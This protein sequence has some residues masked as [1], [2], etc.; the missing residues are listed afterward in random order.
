[1]SLKSV[2]NTVW[3]VVEPKG[4][5]S[6]KE[7]LLFGKFAKHDGR[8]AH[9]NMHK[10][11]AERESVGADDIKF[12]G[13]IKNEEWRGSSLYNNEEFRTDMSVFNE[14]N[15]SDGV[16]ED[17]SDDQ[18]SVWIR[19]DALEGEANKNRDCTKAQL[20]EAKKL[21]KEGKFNLVNP[22]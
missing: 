7:P 12:A 18:M 13:S 15:M 16:G 1:M 22:R 19:E 2:N 3:F 5:G 11:L 9:M 20:D 21:F 10:Y 4:Y 14:H 6:Y 8:S 17:V